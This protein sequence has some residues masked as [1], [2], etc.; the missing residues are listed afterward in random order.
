MSG[1]PSIVF[2]LV[3]LGPAMLALLL[4]D[5]SRT[6]LPDGVTEAEKLDATPDASEGQLDRV[7]AS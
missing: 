4:P 5:T 6:P 2:A 3:A 1:L 7:I